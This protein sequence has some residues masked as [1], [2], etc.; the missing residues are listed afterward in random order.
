MKNMLTIGAL[1]LT[2]GSYAS[3]ETGPEERETQ[4]SVTQI[5]ASRSCF[6]EIT[7]TGCPHPADDLKEFRSCMHTMFQDLS[8]DC[9]ARMKRL[10]GSGN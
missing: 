4:P 2:L 9:Q 5:Q 8:T 3:I 6:Q 7:D 10:Y 1:L